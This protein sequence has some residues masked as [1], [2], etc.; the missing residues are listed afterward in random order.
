MVYYTGLMWRKAKAMEPQESIRKSSHDSFE[1][2]EHFWGHMK[3]LELKQLLAEVHLDKAVLK[4]VLSK[5]C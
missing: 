5:N 2:A 3:I 1:E 4:E